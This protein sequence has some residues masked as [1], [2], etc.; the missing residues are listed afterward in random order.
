MAVPSGTDPLRRFC[1]L[2]DLYARCRPSYPAA[3]LDFI[4]ARCGLHRGSLLVDVG[5]GTGI[6]ARLFAERGVPVLGIEP[7]DEMRCRAEAEVGPPGLPAPRYCKGCAEATQL[8]D[9]MADAV[10]AAQA[11]HWFQP[12]AALREFARILKP[13]GWVA[14]LWNERDPSDPFTA[15][16][17][18]VIRTAPE[19][20]AVETPRAQAGQALLVSPPFEHGE[21]VRFRHEQVLDEAG[22]LGRAFSASYA[23]REP[24]GAE[25]FAAALR[26]VFHG[27]QRS[28]QVT[29][30]YETSVYVARRPLVGTSTGC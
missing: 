15:A 7:N 29:L 13:G 22:V 25:R 24:A 26:A 14:L 16:Y 2:A 12:E 27:F 1:G 10:L 8:P 18:A 19:A 23:P 5:C 11:F 30:R 28:G 20:E 6:A 4:I 3:A 9:R 17:G 21:C